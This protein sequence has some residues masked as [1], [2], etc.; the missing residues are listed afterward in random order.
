VSASWQL[1]P[2][3][4]A[5][6]AGARGFE[7]AYARLRFVPGVPAFPIVDRLTVPF[8]DVAVWGLS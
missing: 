1:G 7:D 6:V 4:R 5:L 2:A 3:E 8:Y